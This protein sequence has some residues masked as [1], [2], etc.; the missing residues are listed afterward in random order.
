MNENFTSLL[1]FTILS[2][3]AVGTLIFRELILL[4]GWFEFIS[5]QFRKRSLHVIVILLF[6]SLVIAFLHLGNPL[7]AF[8]AIKNFGKSWLSREIFSLSLL[9]AALL[10]YLI[11]VLRNNHLRTE[12]IISFIS[13]MLCISFVYSMIKLYMIPSV[14]SWNNP[15]TPVSFI[16]TTFLCGL[17]LLAVIIWKNFDGFNYIIALLTAILVIC[18][19]ANSILFYG[20][21][22]KQVY[23][24]FIIR[25]ALSIISLL[26][27]TVLNFRFQSNKTGIWWVILSLIVVVSEIINRYIFFLSFEKSGL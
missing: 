8:N 26:I 23:Y 10:L 5:Y 27:I 2:Q 25:T 20:T 1:F 21:F 19:L 24:L 11:I 16:I 9:M 12:R 4:R 7:H 3:M 14:I 22:L 15:F 6:L 13:V 18:S 17:I